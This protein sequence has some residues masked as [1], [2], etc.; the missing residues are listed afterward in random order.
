MLLIILLAAIVDFFLG[1]VIG[2]K[3]SVEYARGFVGYNSMCRKFIRV[4]FLFHR[5]INLYSAGTMLNR[6]LWRDYRPYDGV[7]H[8]FFSVLAIFFPAATGILAGANISG[9]LKVFAKSYNFQS[10]LNIKP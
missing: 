9:D 7:E 3:S 10:L 1:S 5:F 8:S 6:N 4:L 2:P